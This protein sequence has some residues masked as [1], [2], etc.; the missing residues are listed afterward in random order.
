M[1]YV[2]CVDWKQEVGW[3]KWF[4]PKSYK[5][6]WGSLL[7]YI[8]LCFFYFSWTLDIWLEEFE[9]VVYACECEW[10]PLDVLCDL[11]R[12]DVH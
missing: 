12:H 4:Q 9:S 8:C 3:S 5:N 2:I 10:W 1:V 7:Y 11:F 6:F